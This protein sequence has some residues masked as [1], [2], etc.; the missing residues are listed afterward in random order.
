MRGARDT[1]RGWLVCDVAVVT[2]GF[3]LCALGCGLMLAGW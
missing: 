3:G 1:I 2:V